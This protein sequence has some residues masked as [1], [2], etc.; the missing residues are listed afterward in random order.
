MRNNGSPFIIMNCSICEIK[1]PFFI[2]LPEK[3]DDLNIPLHKNTYMLIDIDNYTFLYYVYC[4]KCMEM[5]LDN[6]PINFKKLQ[7]RELCGK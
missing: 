6:Y 4:N 7:K 3:A 2:M 1:D 5:Y